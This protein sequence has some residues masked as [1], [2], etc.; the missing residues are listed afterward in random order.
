MCFPPELVPLSL[1]QILSGG[2]ASALGREKEVQ[3]HSWDH[4]GSGDTD[5]E[6]D[7]SV[8]RCLPLGVS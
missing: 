2:D 5:A 7:S 6:S 3:R 1:Q 4:S 8:S